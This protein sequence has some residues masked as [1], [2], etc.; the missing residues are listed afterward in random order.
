MEKSQCFYSSQQTNHSAQRERNRGMITPSRRHKQYLLINYLFVTR[1]TTLIPIVD[2]KRTKLQ[3][4]SKIALVGGRNTSFSFSI[5][6]TRRKISNKQTTWLAFGSWRNEEHSHVPLNGHQTPKQYCVQMEG[7]IGVG[8]C[9]L[10]SPQT[11]VVLPVDTTT[12]KPENTH[13]NTRV[14]LCKKEGQ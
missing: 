6:L 12:Q 3:L 10:L 2:G 5:S 9:L 8:L 1:F 4:S 11:L 13:L 14:K 7:R